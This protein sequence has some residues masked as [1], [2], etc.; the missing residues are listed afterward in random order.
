MRAR[1]TD[2]ALARAEPPTTGRLELPDGTVPGLV[3]RITPDGVRTFA[4]RYRV[5]GRQRRLTLGRYPVISIADARK[6]A[7]DA[8]HK[9]AQGIDPV[10]EKE[11]DRRSTVEAVVETFLKERVR[12]R[13]KT[14]KETE[15][16]YDRYV[17]RNWGDRPLASITRGT[18]AR[19]RGI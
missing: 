2:L 11:A 5:R 14:A 8:L 7:R 1:L 6:L 15:Q 12:P 18:G 19:S 9:V 10:A 4:L 16:I 3:C 17:V 13:L